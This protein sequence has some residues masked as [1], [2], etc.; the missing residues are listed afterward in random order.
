M[1]SQF[2]QNFADNG[3]NESESSGAERN[4]EPE[5]ETIS[6]GTDIAAIAVKANAN[7]SICRSLDPGSNVMDASDLH[8]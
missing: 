1:Q 5:R 2:T 3:Q 8:L 4:A 6:P 7:S